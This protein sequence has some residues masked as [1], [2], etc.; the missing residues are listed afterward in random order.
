[1]RAVVTGA[2]GFVGSHFVDRLLD[3]GWEV[4]GV[5]NLLTG[6]SHNLAPA[7]RRNGF[8]FLEADV[9]AGGFASEVL[10]PL[11]PDLIAHLASPASP[12][13][14]AAH[15]SETM[16]ANSSG[17]Q[18]C[19]EAALSAGG[20]LLFA[21]TSEVYGDPLEHPQRETY[22]GNVN[23]V[24]PRSPYDESKRFGEALVMA[25]AR[26]HGLDATIVR[27]FNTYGPRMR[28]GDGRVIPAFIAQ[29]LRGEPLPIYGDGSQ[30]RSFCYVTDLVEGLM[31]VA[32][33]GRTRAQV[34]NVGNPREHTIMEVARLVSRLCGREPRF[35]FEPRPQDDPVRRCPDISRAKELI[36]WSPRVE[37]EQGL[38]QTIEERMQAHGASAQHGSDGS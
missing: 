11:R 15:P 37:L 3:S 14:Y 2:A 16:A 32:T 31:R 33:S 22:W 1:M 6:N 12:V 10:A 7:R 5:D 30:T 17:T 18:A 21:S 25:F 13:D 9:T 29:A 8:R 38:K 19:A 36:D 28:P 23:P 4:V 34:I 24:G 26:T 27:I 20:R 35:R